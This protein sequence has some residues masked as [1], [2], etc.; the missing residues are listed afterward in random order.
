MLRFVDVRAG[1]R[2]LAMLVSGA[3]VLALAAQPA[4]AGNEAIFTSTQAYVGASSVH[5]NAFDD[6]Y[7]ARDFRGARTEVALI[8]RNA[9]TARAVLAKQ[10]P[11]NARG[12]KG[13]KALLQ[14]W[15][16]KQAAAAELALAVDA[17]AARHPVTAK[18]H[19]ASFDKLA[20]KAV[21]L[22]YVGIPLLR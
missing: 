19:L 9:V 8:A 4:A 12:A 1:R 17:S 15:S 7:T 16:L 20:N 3:V 22:L 5:Q 6:K 11:S 2:F 14:Y 18:R 13:K 21:G 10:T